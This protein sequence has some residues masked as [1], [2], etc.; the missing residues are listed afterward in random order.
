MAVSLSYRACSSVLTMVAGQSAVARPGRKP[1]CSAGEWPTNGRRLDERQ[2]AYLGRRRRTLFTKPTRE[3]SLPAAIYS[4]HT[5]NT[6]VHM[7]SVTRDHV[8]RLYR[9]LSTSNDTEKRTECARE[10]VPLIDQSAFLAA[11]SSRQTPARG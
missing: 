2:P 9:H 6:C 8:C 3:L 7:W 4:K 1:H 10:E 5:Y 11:L